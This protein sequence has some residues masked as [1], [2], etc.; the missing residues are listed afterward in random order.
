MNA[1]GESSSPERPSSSESETPGPSST[2]LQ[3][4]VLS[5]VQS[6]TEQA[7][8]L[9]N[10]SSWT[11]SSGHASTSALIPKVD[12]L[13]LGLLM[14]RGQVQAAERLAQQFVEDLKALEQ[15]Q[16][17]EHMRRLGLEPAALD[18]LTPSSPSVPRNG[19]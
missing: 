7:R 15:E 16:I 18:P 14:V 1:S 4:A 11:P 6:L 19:I 9:L 12:Q 10:I 3:R 2:D 13:I 5:S 8:S 17:N